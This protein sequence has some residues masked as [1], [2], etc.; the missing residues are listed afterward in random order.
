M[1][2]PEEKLLLGSTPADTHL[3]G[4]K[5]TSSCPYSPVRWL[6]TCSFSKQTPRLWSSFRERVPCQDLEETQQQTSVF[7]LRQFSFPPVQGKCERQRNK[8]LGT[9]TKDE[10]AKF[11][12]CPSQTCSCLPEYR[13][14]HGTSPR[15][16]RQ[17]LQ[18]PSLSLLAPPSWFP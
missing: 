12:S 10:P 6:D 8:D 1:H 16:P 3:R 7:V 9:G 13:S 17:N 2:R 5:V 14:R 15:H 18:S 11:R 4:S